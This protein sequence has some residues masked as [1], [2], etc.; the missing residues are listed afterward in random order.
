MLNICAKFHENSTCTFREITSV[1][2]YHNNKNAQSQSLLAEVTNHLATTTPGQ[3][4]D[5]VYSS[6]LKT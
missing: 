6:K 1:Q 3:E 4:M 5:R 2:N